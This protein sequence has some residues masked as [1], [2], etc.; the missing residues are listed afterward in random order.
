MVLAIAVAGA[1]AGGVLLAYGV[2]QALFGLFHMHARSL[3]AERPAVK[4]AA[5]QV[6]Q[7]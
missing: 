5:P 2:C 7:S 4:A 1:L 3:K 6:V